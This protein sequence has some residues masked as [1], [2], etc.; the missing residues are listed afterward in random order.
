MNTGDR[1]RTEDNLHV[2]FAG[3]AENAQRLREERL[4][5]V[6]GQFVEPSVLVGDE[7]EP[8]PALAATFNI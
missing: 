3:S 7:T 4:R 5:D 8:R 2:E 6:Q 1:I